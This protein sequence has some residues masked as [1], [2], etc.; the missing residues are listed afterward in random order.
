MWGWTT[1]LSAIDVVVNG[2]LTKT[3]ARGLPQHRRIEVSPKLRQRR[4]A[5]QREVAAHELAHLA[6]HETYGPSAKPHGSE[7]AGLMRAAG[8]E[9]RAVIG[10]CRGS[11]RAGGVRHPADVRYEHRCPVCQFVRWARRPVPRW[12]CRSCVEAGLDGRLVV[13]LLARP[14]KPL[15]A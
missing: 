8:F 10:S 1:D 7:W 3:L 13:S 2:R 4:L 6:V 12:R 15:D 9:P 14:R 5:L 11:G